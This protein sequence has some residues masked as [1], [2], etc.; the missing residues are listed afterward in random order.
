[1]ARTIQTQDAFA[2]GWNARQAGVVRTANPFVSAYDVQDW[3]FGWDDAD[4]SLYEAAERDERLEECEE[5]AAR[6]K[7]RAYAAEWSA[8]GPDPLS[9][10]KREALNGALAQIERAF[11]KRAVVPASRMEAA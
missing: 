5:R 2:A 3:N 11:G 8:P 4:R 10:D 7:V 9:T 1:V 6:R